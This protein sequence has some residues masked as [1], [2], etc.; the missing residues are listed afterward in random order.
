YRYVQNKTALLRAVN[1]A[2]LQAL[3]SALRPVLEQAGDAQTRSLAVARAYRAFAHANPATYG[4]VYTNTIAVLRPDAAEQEQAVLPFQAL[5]AEITGEAL[6]LSA[7][8]GFLA[9]LH[10]FVMLEISGQFQRG[11]DLDAAFEQ[12]INA[13]LAGWQAR[14]IL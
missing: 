2:T 1:E 8:R 3:F 4:L 9:L 12:S 13:Y 6:S 5:L 7:L 14:H 11:G 10:G